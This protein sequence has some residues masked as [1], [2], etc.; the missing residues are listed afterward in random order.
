MDPSS[1][2]NKK[3]GILYCRTKQGISQVKRTSSFKR[4]AQGNDS[5]KRLNEALQRKESVGQSFSSAQFHLVL[6]YPS[7]Q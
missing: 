4:T 7:V 1:K 5:R 2:A 3:E 6:I